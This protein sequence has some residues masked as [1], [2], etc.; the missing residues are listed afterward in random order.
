VALPRGRGSVVGGAFF[1]GRAPCPGIPGAAAP[2]G[3]GDSIPSISG[4][5]AMGLR[6]VG[7]LRRGLA[8]T[9]AGFGARPA[10]EA[11][12]RR[13][14]APRRERSVAARLCPL[15][16]GPDGGAGAGRTLAP[17]EMPS[18]ARCRLYL[19]SRL[20][21]AARVPRARAAPGDLGPPPAPPLS[22]SSQGHAVPGPRHAGL[23]L[24]SSDQL[25]AV[26]RRCQAHQVLL[27]EAGH[28]QYTGLSTPRARS[29]SRDCANPR[30][31]AG[32]GADTSTLPWCAVPLH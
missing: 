4:S 27:E 20:T 3:T 31:D 10:P 23:S 1:S 11:P 16:D 15:A 2:R 5:S 25:G 26:R 18:G 14:A 19:R 17:R 24:R 21:S 32:T 13:L 12:F 7:R 30:P 6:A 28:P 22:F 9:C 8:P 29:P